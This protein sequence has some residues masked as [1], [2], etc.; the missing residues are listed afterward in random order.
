M[1]LGAEDVDGDGK[2]EIF[3]CLRQDLGQGVTRTILLIYRLSPRGFSQIHGREIAR[4]YQGNS[5]VN[6]YRVAGSGKARRLIV[7]PGEAKGFSQENWPFGSIVGDPYAPCFFRGP[8][9]KS[10]FAS[11]NPSAPSGGA[12]K[13]EA[14]ECSL[15]QLLGPE[16]ARANALSRAAKRT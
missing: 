11:S 5:I 13:F 6:R 3:V 15:Q 9:A 4:Q 1:H 7:S 10:D 8:A 14:F 2:R 12:G 16:S